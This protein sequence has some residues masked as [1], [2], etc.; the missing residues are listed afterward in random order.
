MPMRP[1]VN[2]NLVIGR[3]RAFHIFQE[4]Y[5]VCPARCK[6]AECANE[7]FSQQPLQH[8]QAVN[9]YEQVPRPFTA[10][11]HALVQELAARR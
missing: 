11:L 3:F 1:I 8:R 2:S 7:I 5:V 9:E 6:L 10:A 4:S